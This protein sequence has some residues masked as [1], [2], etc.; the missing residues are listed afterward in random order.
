MK[1]PEVVVKKS[2]ESWLVFVDTNILLD[3][4]RLRGDS[5]LRQLAALERHKDRLIT[6][7][8]IRMEYLKHRQHVVTETLRELKKPTDQNLPPILAGYKPAQMMKKHIVNAEQKFREVKQKAEKIISDPTHHDEVYKSL[9]RIFDHPSMFNLTRAQKVRF[10]IR[11]RAR[12]RFVLGYPPRKASDNSIGDAL[13]WEWI[14]KCAETC[15]DGSHVLI[16]SRDSDFGL[17]DSS[18]SL[19]NDWLRREFKERTSRKRKIELTSRLTYAMKKL[20]EV[21]TLADVKEEESLIKSTRKKKFA[22]LFRFAQGSQSASLLASKYTLGDLLN[23]ADTE[24]LAQEFEID[25]GFDLSEEPD[26]D[27]DIDGSEPACGKQV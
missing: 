24:E 12:K 16:V 26:I 5:A 7:D 25:M 23:A 4:Y 13:N 15:P 27:I 8:Q 11:N 20:D 18:T 6:S 21:V 19:L 14:V 9:S 17:H 1:Q 22:E 2:K 10:E 3:F